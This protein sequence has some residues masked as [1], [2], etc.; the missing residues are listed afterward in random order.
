MK[1]AMKRIFV[2]FTI[3][4]IMAAVF[5][6][7]N[8]DLGF[9]SNEKNPLPA[10]VPMISKSSDLDYD[11]TPQSSINSTSKGIQLHFQDYP[12]GE[13][14]KNIHDE[15]GILFS[16]SPQMA[17]SP[18]SIDIGARNWKSSVRKLIADY[19]RVEVW[20]NRPKTSRIWLMESTLHD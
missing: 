1:V 5:A 10:P 7:A 14:L 17:N 9:R 12:L 8:P 13:L 3:V 19:S 11:P 20:T 4:A 6:Y 2:G 18:I 15:T 16:L